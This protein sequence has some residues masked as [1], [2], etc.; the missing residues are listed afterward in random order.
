MPIE[1]GLEDEFCPEVDN[2]DIFSMPNN[3]RFVPWN[4]IPSFWTP[5]PLN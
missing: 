5:I 2:N 3:R 1:T 4:S